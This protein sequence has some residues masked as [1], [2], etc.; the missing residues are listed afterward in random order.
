MSEIVSW[1]FTVLESTLIETNVV[2]YHILDLRLV[3]G[4]KSLKLSHS[5]QDI[6]GQGRLPQYRWIP[7]GP[8]KL[9]IQKDSGA[10]GAGK[11]MVNLYI[12]AIYHVIC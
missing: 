3:D 6:G 1:F 2:L 9:I 8:T 7:L 11:L 4:G 5:Q 12:R 10:K